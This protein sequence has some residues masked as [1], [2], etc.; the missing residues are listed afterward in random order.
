MMQ[1]SKGSLVLYIQVTST[2]V[3]SCLRLFITSPSRALDLNSRLGYFQS[4][5]PDSFLIVAVML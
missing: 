1:G 2:Y 3:F 4:I 5:H